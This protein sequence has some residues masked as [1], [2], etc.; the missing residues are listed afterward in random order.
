MKMYDGKGDNEPIEFDE[1]SDGEHNCTLTKVVECQKPVWKNGEK[2]D[3]TVDGLR[4]V[5]K[6]FDKK[7]WI[8]KTVTSTTHERGALYKLLQELH[9]SI[10]RELEFEDGYGLRALFIE[11]INEAVGKNYAVKCEKN[12][13]YVNYISARPISESPNTKPASKT[14][15]ENEQVQDFNDDDIPF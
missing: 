15:V 4:F 6:V 2:L 11:K 10:L 7:A 3:Q 14:L 1:I 12:G 8:C 13:D 5:F 9:D